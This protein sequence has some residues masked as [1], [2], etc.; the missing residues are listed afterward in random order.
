MVFSSSA[1]Q[2]WGSLHQNRLRN[3]FV[4]ILTKSDAWHFDSKSNTFFEY[5]RLG[6]SISQP[7]SNIWHLLHLY[8]FN[9]IGILTSHQ[10]QQHVIP[11]YYLSQNFSIKSKC[12]SLVNHYSWVKSDVNLLRR[13]NASYLEIDVCG[14][15]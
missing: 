5:Q 9:N 3:L 13:Q 11:I 10:N 1:K 8:Q 4:S 14:R 2:K 7:P 12:I 6:Q 15:D